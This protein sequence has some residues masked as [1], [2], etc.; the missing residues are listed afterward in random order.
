MHNLPDDFLDENTQWWN[1]NGPLTEQLYTII[2]SFLTNLL[3]RNATPTYDVLIS[4]ISMGLGG[5]SLP[6]S[7]HRA[8]PDFIITMASDMKMAND[9]ITFN[10]DLQLYDDCPNSN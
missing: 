3:G 1:W 10:K 4:Q 5:L 2:F 7:S 8:A 9:G 6:N